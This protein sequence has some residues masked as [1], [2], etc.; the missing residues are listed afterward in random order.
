MKRNIIIKDIKACG[1]KIKRAWSKIKTGKYGRHPIAALI[2]FIV[3]YIFYEAFSKLFDS[4]I[5]GSIVTVLILIT[6]EL[7]HDT[8]NENKG[9]W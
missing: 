5:I 8:L 4:Y 6:Y 9:G 3:F 7:S 2:N 1:R